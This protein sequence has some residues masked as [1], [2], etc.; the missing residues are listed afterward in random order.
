MKIHDQMIEWY[1]ARG[2]KR[3]GFKKSVRAILLEAMMPEEIMSLPGGGLGC[4][5]DAW[6]IVE[7]DEDPPE[8]H[9]L[10]VEVTSCIKERKIKWYDLLWEDCDA[11]EYGCRLFVCGRYGNESEISL[12]DRRYQQLGFQADW[13][14]MDHV[15]LYPGVESIRDRVAD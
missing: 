5:P 12:L 8:I 13:K 10:E 2:W 1:V 6:R 14:P 4:L 9:C 11:T 7:N 3:N 15:S